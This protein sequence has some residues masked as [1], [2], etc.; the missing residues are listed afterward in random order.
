MKNISEMNRYELDILEEQIH[1]Q[2]NALMAAELTAAGVQATSVIQGEPWEYVLVYS[3]VPEMQNAWATLDE[4]RRL[5]DTVANLEPDEAYRRWYPKVS[6]K[7]QGEPYN[8]QQ[9]AADTKA[10]RADLARRYQAGEIDGQLAD[11]Y[12]STSFMDLTEG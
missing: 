10:A 7:Y 9:A 6:I 8:K 11:L 12:K 3:S 1:N 5:L 4:C 2:R